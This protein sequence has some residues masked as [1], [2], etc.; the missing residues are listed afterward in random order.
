MR[1]LLLIL[2]ILCLA[3]VGCAHTEVRENGATVFKTQMNAKRLTYRSPAGS[4][5]SVE[6]M[7][8]STPTRAGG[9]VL[10]TGLTG[11]GGILATWMTGGAAR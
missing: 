4:Y 10:G 9:S 1:L 11:A 3:T 5:L 2:L 7:N 6:G 8:H